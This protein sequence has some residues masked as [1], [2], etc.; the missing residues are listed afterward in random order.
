MVLFKMTV[1]GLVLLAHSWVSW[2]CND[3]HHFSALPHKIVTIHFPVHPS[4]SFRNPLDD[5][6]LTSTPWKRLPPFSW[7]FVYFRN[8]SCSINHQ[9]LRRSARQ[10][11]TDQLPFCL[12]INRPKKG[13]CWV[14]A[15]AEWLSSGTQILT[16]NRRR[17]SMLNDWSHKVRAILKEYCQGNIKRILP[18]SQSAWNTRFY[19]GHQKLCMDNNYIIFDGLEG[20]T[21]IYC[22]RW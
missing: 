10:S 3:F 21:R 17:K 20:D 13:A 19:F 11:V 5:F 8:L 1:T 4:R 6:S 12:L 18:A 14:R 9:I 16:T 7:L 2:F 22:Q 15:C